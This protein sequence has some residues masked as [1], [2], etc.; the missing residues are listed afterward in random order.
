VEKIYQIAYQAS[1]GSVS[2]L[3]LMPNDCA[4]FE[5][6]LNVLISRG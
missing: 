3:E 1:D 4:A 5:D 6:A 2:R